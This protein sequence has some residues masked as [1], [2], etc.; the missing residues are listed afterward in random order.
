MLNIVEDFDQ[1]G[2][3]D[4]YDPD[5]DNDGFS[6]AEELTYGSDPLDS[7]SVANKFPVITLKN[8]YPEQV[9]KNGVFHIRTPENQKKLSR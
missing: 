4:H 2:I 7:K 5:D 8:E 3:E 1:D 9:D 6:D